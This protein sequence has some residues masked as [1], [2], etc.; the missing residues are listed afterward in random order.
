M[1]AE[2]EIIFIDEETLS[3]DE[4]VEGDQYGSEDE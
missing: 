1:N 2:K 4:L 3:H